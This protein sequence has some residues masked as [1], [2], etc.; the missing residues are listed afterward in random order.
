VVATTSDGVVLA[1]DI[2]TSSCRA[3]LYDV[4][5]RPVAERAAHV[6]YAPRFTP[7]GGAELDANSL[8]ERVCQTIDHVL[9]TPL[10]S[11]ILGVATSTF[12]HSLLGL[13]DSGQPLTPVYLWLDARAR[14]EITT[15]RQQL[16]EREV[17]ARTGCVLHS[18]YWP[19]RLRWLQRTQPDIFKK[20]KRWVSFS[21]YLLQ[22]LTQ[23]TYVSTSMASGTGL[24][25]VHT[26]QWYAPMLEYLGL[27]PRQLGALAPLEQTSTGAAR[28]AALGDV[29][30]LLAVG[31]GACSNLGAGCASPDRFALMIG[32]SGAERAVWSPPADFEVPWGLWSYRVDEQRVV[33]GGALNDGGSL[34]DWLRDSLRLPDFNAAEA[35]VAAIEPDSHGLTVLPLWGGERN[36]GWADDARGAIVGLRL[37]TE[38]TAI[39]R[40]CMEGVALRFGAMDRLLLEAQPQAHEVIATGG[41]LLHSPAWMQ[42]IADALGRPVYASAE[43][44]ASSRGAVLLGLEVV[45]SLNGQLEAVRP[46]TTRRFDPIPRNTERYQA[47]AERQRRLYDAF[48]GQIAR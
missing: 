44:E 16:D 42:I 3:S 23:T 6:A 46:S 34:L 43:A 24:L 35:A 32:T 33:M 19:A 39:L 17:H 15:L 18:T 20:A 4:E 27:E 10:P 7:D 29:P 21:E 36:P 22:R 41:A 2:G 1:L 45:G 40:A 38:P 28:W 30:W 26:L 31:D 48:V 47:A 5:A 13:D 12:W 9:A 14:G 37:S 25:D 11:R 8:Y